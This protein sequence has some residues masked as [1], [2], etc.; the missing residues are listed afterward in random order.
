MVIENVRT[1]LVDVVH[2]VLSRPPL[3]VGHP[4]HFVMGHGGLQWRIVYLQ[5][6]SEIRY[7]VLWVTVEDIWGGGWALW[8]FAVSFAGL[9]KFFVTFGVEEKDLH[10]AFSILKSVTTCSDRASD[11][12]YWNAILVS[13]DPIFCF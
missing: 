11:V 12:M 7:A 8:R 6:W 2:F 13:T 9:A 3:A 1:V 4:P 10:A 5:I